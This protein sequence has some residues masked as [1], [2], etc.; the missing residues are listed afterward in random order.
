D[1]LPRGRLADHTYPLGGKGTRIKHIDTMF[2]ILWGWDGDGMQGELVERQHW[3]SKPY[4][5][6]FRR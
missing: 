3:A 5:E 2:A 6:L 4:R 1:V